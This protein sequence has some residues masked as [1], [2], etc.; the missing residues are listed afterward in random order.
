MNFRILSI[1][2]MIMINATISFVWGYTP[3]PANAVSVATFGAKGDGVTDDA[4]ALNTA[5][6]AISQGTNLFFEPGKKYVI[7]KSILVGKK[8]NFNIYG[9]DATIKA[10]GTFVPS[11]ATGGPL[12]FSR[13]SLFTCSDLII[14]GNR[15]QLTISEEWAKMNFYLLTCKDFTI[16]KVRSNNACCD[17]IYL[18][19]DNIYSGFI[20][21][22]PDNWAQL[23]L[24]NRCENGKIIDCSADNAYRDAMSIIFAVNIQVIGGTFTN[25]NGTAPQAGCD[26]EPDGGAIPAT[27]NIL[28][29]G[30]S[31]TGNNGSG[32]LLY[33]AT[34]SRNI[35]VDGCYFK[36]NGAGLTNTGIL[37]VTVKNCVFYGGNKS[38]TWGVINIEPG[39]NNCIVTGNI[40]ANTKNGGTCINVGSNVTATITS[41][42]IYDFTGTAINPAS[43]MA[44]ND[45]QATKVIADP[46]VP[47]PNVISINSSP[48]VAVSTGGKFGYKVTYLNLTKVSTVTVNWLKRPTWVN[49][50]PPDS[51]YGIAPAVPGTDSMKVVVSAGT[52]SDTLVVAIAISYYK[53]LEAETGTLV[54][55]MVA[56]ADPTASGGS[57]ISASTGI[58]TITKKIEA[59]Y[60][61]ANMPAGT[62]FV[63]LKMSIP[64][65]STTNNFGIFVGFGTA[66]NAN[67]LKPK[68]T[69]TYTWVRSSVNFT[70]PA[71]TNTFI[72]GHGLAGAKIDQI[73]LTT[74]WEAALPEN[75][76]SIQKKQTKNQKIGLNGA[77]IMAQPLSGARINFV[78]NGIG[79]GDFTMD[80]FN[81]AGSRVWSDYKK[82]CA[83][84]E[85]QVIWDGTD[86]KLKLTQSGIYVAQISTGNE[87]KQIKVSLKR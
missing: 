41:N 79:I 17:G 53:V 4:S 20:F 51:V 47:N 64:A 83:A 86:N 43:Y 87:S 73:V 58:N 7:S 32:L 59:S 65:G 13:C 46:G 25:S 66:L 15:Q 45:I 18:D 84:S 81:I 6:N 10:S 49:L 3:A 82:G 42:K 38:S 14:D 50:Y 8:T 63:W 62:Y 57:C 44:G 33:K 19:A 12:T 34:H 21:P 5:V 26:V 71:G 27:D 60:T 72:L 77:S 35:T 28:F 11:N 16:T 61:I 22:G 9:Q 31:F 39:S 76:T 78:V 2:L 54:A 40:I 37:N 1:A 55:P 23:K 69:D 30:V 70:L 67:Y 36:G 68:V 24:E 56:V 48:S 80:I 75:Y 85:Y 52:S 29:K 74:S